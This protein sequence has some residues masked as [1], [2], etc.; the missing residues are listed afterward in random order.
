MS[1]IKFAVIGLGHIGKRHADIILN[2][3]DAQLIAIIEPYLK[4]DLSKYQV[5]V[6]RSLT[7]FFDSNIETDIIC[8]ATP[9]YLHCQQAIQCMQNGIDV[10]IEKPMGLTVNECNLVDE[11]AKNLNRN[12]FCVMQ[13]RYSPPSIWLKEIVSANILGKIFY[14]QINCFWNRGEK[15][16][17]P[18]GW[19]GKIAKDGGTLFTQFSHF[20]DT[21]YWIFGDITNI[22]ARFNNYNHQQ[23]IEF[24]DAGFVSFD[25]INGGNGSLN[26]STSA[27]HKN[28]ESSITILAENG[29]IKIGGQYM[30]KV[31]HCEIKDY[32]MPI[33]ATT[34]PPNDYGNYK[35]SAANHEY[36]INNAI[37]TLLGNETIKTPALEGLKVVDIIE[38]IYESRDLKKLKN[39]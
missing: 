29:S 31:L 19:K 7:D 35:G 34:N 30:E 2:N 21:L 8:I 17:Q 23:T 3:K 26:Y 18:D 38:R 13:N 20:V 12:V 37:Q 36:V 9:N 25:L 27:Y 22:N 32:E 6:F 28:I 1:I 24:E 15:Y 5:P 39:K 4:I 14:V 16:Y 33:L 10:I 11:T